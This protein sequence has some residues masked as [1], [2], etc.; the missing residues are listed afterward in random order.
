VPEKSNDSVKQIAV[1]PFCHIYRRRSGKKRK[2]NCNVNEQ[3]VS[4][5]I[6]EYKISKYTCND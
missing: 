3:E 2:S 5:I 1:T 4:K 6:A